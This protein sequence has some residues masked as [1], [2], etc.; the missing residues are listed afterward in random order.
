M[1]STLSWTFGARG[2]GAE[3]RDG[4]EDGDGDGAG[5]VAGLKQQISCFASIVRKCCEKK[6]GAMCF[7]HIDHTL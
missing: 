1:M 5:A 7:H 2:L 3:V 4:A 6:D